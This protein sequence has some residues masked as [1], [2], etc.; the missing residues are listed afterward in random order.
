M[1]MEEQWQPE[2]P[3]TA[4]EESELF[5]QEPEFGAEAEIPVAPLGARLREAVPAT[6]GSGRVYVKLTGQKQG[7]IAGDSTAR[8]HEHWLVGTAFEYEVSVPKDPATGLGTG[9][10]RHGPVTVTV[11]WSS[12]SPL[13]FQ[14]TVTN[15]AL[16]KV[17]FEFP[18]ISA[19]GAEIVV[20]R[21]TLVDASVSFF[22]HAVDPAA[23]PGGADRISFTFRK[24]TI[25]DLV[26]A[27]TATDDWRSSPQGE[28]AEDESRAG[29]T[30]EI[31]G[32]GV[33]RSDAATFA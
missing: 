25:E 13:L 24:I 3:F 10:R 29:E 18:A 23:A 28:V 19:D 8:G 12:A 17:V 16:T 6:Q 9:K 5:V 1:A 31:D 20:E 21:I 14:A 30:Y 11:P 2:S 27:R 15:E 26:A 22:R 33:R 7:D 32:P 4:L